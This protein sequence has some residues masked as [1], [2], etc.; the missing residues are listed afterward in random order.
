M[1]V[2][3]PIKDCSDLFSAEAG[4]AAPAGHVG[5]VP[6]PGLDEPCRGLRVL[7][8]LIELLGCR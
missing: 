4:G 5:L 3:K 2:K 7:T 1:K 8:L 6:P